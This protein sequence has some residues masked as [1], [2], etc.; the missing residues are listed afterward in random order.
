MLR[1]AAEWTPWSEI[2]LSGCC[3]AQRPPISVRRGGNAGR[4]SATT[5]I[6][7]TLHSCLDATVLYRC[8][9]SASCA[10]RGLELSISSS[11]ASGSFYTRL[12]EPWHS[13]DHPRRGLLPGCTTAVLSPRGLDG[14]A[15]SSD[16]TPTRRP[17]NTARNGGAAFVIARR[18]VGVVRAHHRLSS[19]PS[20][21]RVDGVRLCAVFGSIITSLT[22]I[23]RLTSRARRTARRATEP[24]VA[25]LPTT[26]LHVLRMSWPTREALVGRR[27]F[28]TM[29]ASKNA[30]RETRDQWFLS[31]SPRTQLRRRTS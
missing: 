8:C 18:D 12:G 9:A 13:C 5:Q 16:G 24:S 14:R 6:V 20:S 15:L 22:P 2:S 21:G 26:W 25:R 23:R 28:I 1:S 4:T 17:I 30:R 27:Y 31:V 11:S 7:K 19:T 3:H 10:W 29:L